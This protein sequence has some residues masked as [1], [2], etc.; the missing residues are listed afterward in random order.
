MV[1]YA[2]VG[3]VLRRLCRSVTLCVVDSST[4]KLMLAFVVG[5][6]IRYWDKIKKDFDIVQNSVKMVT[7]PFISDYCSL[8]PAWVHWCWQSRHIHPSKM[9][10]SSAGPCIIILSTQNRTRN[11]SRPSS[12]MD[13]NDYYSV[14]ESL[15]SQNEVT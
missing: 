2:L 15:L 12:M 5:L 10:A 7:L 1:D 4:P 3:S 13:P 6:I 8:D 9:T 11:W 14:Y